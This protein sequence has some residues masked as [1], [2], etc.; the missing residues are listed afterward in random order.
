MCLEPVLDGLSLES[1]PKDGLDRVSHQLGVHDPS[2]GRGA[3]QIFAIKLLF[4]KAANDAT[5]YITTP[6]PKTT[7]AKEA[8]L[9]LD[10]GVCKDNRGGQLL[11]RHRIRLVC[12]EPV[13][14]GLSLESLPKDGLDRVSHQLERDGTAELVGRIDHARRRRLGLRHARRRHGPRERWSG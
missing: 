4:L 3:F 6:R 10:L 5:C 2:H 11:A 12:L 1:L 13:L 14:D 8:A 9:L 7:H